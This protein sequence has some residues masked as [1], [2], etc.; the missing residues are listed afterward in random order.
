MTR[1]TRPSAGV[2]IIGNEVL[3]GKVQERN[4]AFF[5]TRFRA[6]GVRLDRVAIIPDS[7][8]EIGSTVAEFSRRY[9]L[10]CTTGGI[11][12]THDDLTVE[13]IAAGFGVEVEESPEIRSRLEARFDIAVP[14][15]YLRMARVPAGATIEY[16]SGGRWGTIRYGN[17]FIFPGVPGLLRRNFDAIKGCFSGHPMYTAAIHLVT[18]E[19]SICEMLETVVA[20][21]PGVEF[22]SYP[23][24]TKDGW[25][26]RITVEAPGADLCQLALAELRVRFGAVMEGEDPVVASNAPQPDSDR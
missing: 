12:P 23:S 15:T 7:P 5:V 25:T 2:V 22:G 11:G 13:A 26:L 20:A 18:D 4:I 6:A 24:V 10:V 14:A 1:D 19:A 9:D 3:S 16:G 21:H 17:V 8:E